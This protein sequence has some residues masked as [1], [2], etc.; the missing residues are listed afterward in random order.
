MD[1]DA[2][3][4]PLEAGTEVVECLFEATEQP[5]TNDFTV[6]VQSAEDDFGDE[7]D[8]DD[9]DVVVSSIDLDD[10]ANLIAERTDSAE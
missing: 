7:V 4:E 10:S 8:V 6:E 5:T 3:D 2:P 1:L 9:V